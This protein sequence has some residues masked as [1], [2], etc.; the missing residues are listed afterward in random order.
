M[1]DAVSAAGTYLS[2]QSDSSPSEYIELAEVKSFGGPNQDS[3]EIDV[4]HLRSPGRRRE[5][6]QSFL[7]S[8]ELPMN[9]NALLGNATHQQ[10]QADYDS[11][12]VV[13]YKLTFPDT[14]TATFDAYVKSIGVAAQVG[15]AL[16][17]NGTLRITGEIT[18][19]YAP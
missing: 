10:L 2:R 19:A 8:G 14:S 18:W 15:N 9:L 3:E 6:L 12:D 11:G 17:M 4:T 1:S 5:Y 13:E 7:D 16:E